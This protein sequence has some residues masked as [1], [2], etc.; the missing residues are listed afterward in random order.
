MQRLIKPMVDLGD[1]AISIFTAAVP[2]HETE[3]GIHRIRQAW[4]IINPNASGK[5]SDFCFR[6]SQ[7]SQKKKPPI[8]QGR[9]SHSPLK[10]GH[11]RP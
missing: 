5:C 6:S 3:D 1:V 4:K 10:E 9:G 8:P 2:L 7:F 11:I